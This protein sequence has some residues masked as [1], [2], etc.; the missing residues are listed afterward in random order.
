MH[1]VELLSVSFVD[2][3][4]PVGEPFSAILVTKRE[5][6]TS[7]EQEELF[8]SKNSETEVLF[9]LLALTYNYTPSIFHS[10]TISLDK[11]VLRCV[12]PPK[13]LNYLINSIHILTLILQVFQQS[14]HLNKTL[15]QTPFCTNQKVLSST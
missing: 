6:V 7:N 4:R 8:S 14:A 5:R 2:W 9:L 11:K 10:K 1:T 12:N 3:S 15:S 13:F